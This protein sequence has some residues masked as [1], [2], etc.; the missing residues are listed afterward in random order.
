MPTEEMIA[1]TIAKLNVIWLAGAGEGLGGAAEGSGGAAEERS[2][3][4]G[5]SGGA[6]EGP[7]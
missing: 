2:G 1:E 4:E 6:D 3:A 7:S 5:E